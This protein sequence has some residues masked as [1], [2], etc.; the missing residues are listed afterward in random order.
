MPPLE[1]DKPSGR[2]MDCE[3]NPDHRPSKSECLYHFTYVQSSLL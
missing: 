2:G 1:E 3:C